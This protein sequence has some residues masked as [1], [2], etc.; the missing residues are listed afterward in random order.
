MNFRLS[1]VHVLFFIL[2]SGSFGQDTSYVDPVDTL[3]PQAIFNGYPVKMAPGLVDLIDRDIKIKAKRHLTDGY[4]IQLYYGRREQAMKLK[5]EYQQLLGTDRVYVE[6]EQPYFKTRIG[7]FRTGLEAEKYLR[8]MGEY[9]KGCFVVRD[10]IAFP[11]IQELS[12]PQ[13]PDTPQ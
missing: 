8:S 13:L 12:S 3:V 4:R 10:E 7:D 6:Y 5:A 9:C 1:V 11:P 2:P